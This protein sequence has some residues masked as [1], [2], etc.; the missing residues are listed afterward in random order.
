MVFEE[1]EI[2]Q[3]RKNIKPEPVEHS[4][5]ISGMTKLQITENNGKTGEKSTEDL[6]DLLLSLKIDKLKS[7]GPNGLIQRGKPQARQPVNSNYIQ[8]SSFPD[9][10]FPDLKVSELYGSVVKVDSPD[11]FPYFPNDN[12]IGHQNIPK[13]PPQNNLVQGVDFSCQVWQ[14]Q[15]YPYW[16]YNRRSRPLPGR[17][18]P[19]VSDG[20]VNLPS[21]NNSRLPDILDG[22]GS[23]SKSSSSNDI[24]TDEVPYG[25]TYDLDDPFLRSLTD[26]QFPL[27]EEITNLHRGSKDFEYINENSNSS[28]SDAFSQN[29]PFSQ[30]SPLNNH[31]DSDLNDINNI[32][33]EYSYTTSPSSK[34]VTT[35][36]KCRLSPDTVEVIDPSR[37]RRG[38]DG[39]PSPPKQPHLDFP[40]A[41]EDGD[42]VLHSLVIADD[43]TDDDMEKILYYLELDSADQLS[44]IIDKQNNMWRTALFLAVLSEKTEF[45]QCLL[46][47]GA[48]PNIQGKIQYSA[49]T[50]DL[51]TPLMLSVERGDN[52]LEITK[53]LL[54]SPDMNINCRSESDRLTALHIALKSHR[55]P[56]SN[57]G[58]LDCTKTVKL[59][60]MNE[61]DTDLGE[62]R[63]SKTPL[64]LVIDTCDLSLVKVFIN[65]DTE[66]NPETIRSKMNATTRSGDT[67]LHFA[68]GANFERKKKCN[69]LRLLVNSGADSS[70]ENNEKEKPESITT[71]DLWKEAFKC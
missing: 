67:A 70:I 44:D 16:Q 54:E 7:K 17:S 4:D 47:H 49:D 24:E 61:A 64:M 23:R 62:D 1:S 58:G 3:T 52:S 15:N 34:V 39:Q 63:S 6:C 50:Y 22:P 56:S 31:V 5:F 14:R 45:V 66:K 13:F 9:W 30:S 51:R 20:P 27:F 40:D 19:N 37:K 29:S 11:G 43:F 2:F 53:M 65:C 59:L 21:R 18:D 38:Q 12:H 8:K 33:N 68:A 42:S 71:K 32:I 10:Q 36:E 69:L 55:L 41:D 25:P 48:D 26:Q 57:R 46:D 60:I 35:L 28:S